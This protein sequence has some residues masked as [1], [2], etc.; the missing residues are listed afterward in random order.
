MKNDFVVGQS[1]SSTKTEKKQNRISNGCGTIIQGI[2]CMVK[3]LER[4]EKKKYLKQ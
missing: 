4:K 3:I 1:S 2:T